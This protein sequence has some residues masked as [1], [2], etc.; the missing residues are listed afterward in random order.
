MTE[1]KVFVQDGRLCL[2]FPWTESNVAKAKEIPCARWNKKLRAWQYPLNRKIYLK[3]K[4]SFG[5]QCLEIEQLSV[6]T[7]SL[8]D[9]N[10][11]TPPYGHQ[12]EGVIFLLQQF[13]IKVVEE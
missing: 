5:L 10:F 6:K 11:K 3:I 8:K 12:R 4:E 7:I 2:R 13:G 9:Y 1:S